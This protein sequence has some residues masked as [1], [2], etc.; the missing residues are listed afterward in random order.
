MYRHLTVSARLHFQ[1]FTVMYVRFA[2]IIRWSFTCKSTRQLTPTKDS[3]FTVW[4][5]LAPRDF[6][7]HNGRAIAGTRG[8]SSVSGWHFNRW[9]KQDRAP[10]A[11]G[12]GPLA[13]LQDAELRLKRDKC[14]FMEQEVTYLGHRISALG[15]Q[16]TDSFKYMLMPSGSQGVRIQLQ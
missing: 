6:P 7:A 16:P 8:G 5:S 4:C 14:R 10:S 13:R 2:Y 1:E 15:L 9:K 3:P 11:P 12:G